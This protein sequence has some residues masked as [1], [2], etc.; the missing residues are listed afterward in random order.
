M[1]FPFI[2]AEKMAFPLT[3]LCRVLQVSRAGYYAWKK[4]KKSARQIEDERLTKAMTEAHQKSRGTYG[5][6]RL[7]AA[8]R[9]QGK[10]HSRKRVI[11]L[12][13][14]AGLAASVRRRFQKTTDSKHR[15]PVAPNVLARSFAV[16]P[17]QQVWTTDITYIP[18]WQ[19]WLYLAVILDLGSRR[20]VG[21]A[22]SECIDTSLV[23]SAFTMACQGRKPPKGLVHHSDRGS[24]YASLAYQQA[25]AK[26]DLVGS[27]SRKGNC[28][29]NAVTESFFRGLKVE[30]TDRHTFQTHGQA[31]AVIFEHIEV[32]YNRQRLHSSLGY[33]SPVEYEQS[34]QPPR[35]RGGLR[36]HLPISLSA[37]KPISLELLISKKIN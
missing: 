27:M 28:W 7:Q 1:K 23:I 9:R 33:R 6:P 15:L 36:F 24:Q 11:R 16:G 22:M 4:R 19:G 5:S 8:L 37:T 34:L 31:K 10:K 2:E 18:T 12:M 35:K 30:C 21:W 20:V 17:V 29:D 14:K 13:K 26:A 3:L 32:F 25:L